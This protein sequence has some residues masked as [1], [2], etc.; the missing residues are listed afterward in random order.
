MGNE[1]QPCCLPSSAHTE[2]HSISNIDFSHRVKADTK[3]MVRIGG[4]YLMG[5]NDPEQF[6]L[7][8]ESPVRKIHIDAF[9]IDIYE[10]TIGQFKK[11][12]S[13]TGYDFNRWNDVSDYSATDDH[14]IVYV[15]WTD[16]K[17]YAKWV[18]KRLPTE[19]EWEHATRGGLTNKRYPW[20]DE[21]SRDNANYEGVEGSDHW[22]GETAPVGSFAPNGYGIYDMAGNV[23]EWCADWYG[24]GYY[25]R[26]SMRNPKGPKTGKYRVLRGGSWSDRSYGLRVAY[27]YEYEPTAGHYLGGFR[28]VSESL[29]P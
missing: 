11:F 2:K 6:P 8:G 9:Y 20:G 25:S 23:W 17:A 13:Q 5:T 12:V 22:D 26:S 4:T 1:L 24:E 28:C 3:N 18:G 14:P 10:A 15:T 19:A 16:A 27:R 29:E 7:D 21:L